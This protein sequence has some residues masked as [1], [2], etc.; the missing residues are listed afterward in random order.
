MTTFHI[1]LDIA[2]TLRQPNK[3]ID[4]LIAIDGRELSAK[5]VRHFLHNLRAKNPGQTMFTGDRC[6]NQGADGGCLGHP[7]AQEPQA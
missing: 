3:H 1:G 7:G 4:G 2:G 5:E 6:D